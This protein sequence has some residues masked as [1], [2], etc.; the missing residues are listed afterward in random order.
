VKPASWIARHKAR[1]LV[2]AAFVLLVAVAGVILAVGL[3][4]PHTSAAASTSTSTGAVRRVVIPEGASAQKIAAILLEEGIIES[5]E[6]FLQAVQAEAAATRL[7]PG[8]YELRPGQ[9]YGSIIAKLE[10]GETSP[11]LTLTIPEGLAI[12]QTAERL[13][14]QGRL[15]GALYAKLAGRPQDHTV[16]PVGGSV[17]KVTTL[18]G[19]LFPSTYALTESDGPAELISQ[20][21]KTFGDMTA[22]L[23][24]AHTKD[25]SIT[26]YQAVIVA[27]LVEKEA[28]IPEER[29]LVAAV[30]YNRLAKK[31]PLGID[32]TTRYA[33]KKWTGALTKSDLETDSPY[34]TRSR[35]GLPPGPI[36]SPGVAALEAALTPAKVDYLYYVLIDK[37]GHHFFTAS[38]EE[39]LKAKG[40]TPAP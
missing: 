32:A 11:E 14:A 34:N 9:A 16:P 21:L 35:P 30:I 7:K 4:R 12:G 24:W 10:S 33:L 5:P 25:L 1:V 37:D 6:A 29:P 27:S 18:E 3:G 19:L 26:P 22:G 40:Q 13:D 8:T 23:L 15:D 38:Y 36:A 2:A 31:M 39:F 20:Q 28:S 17:P